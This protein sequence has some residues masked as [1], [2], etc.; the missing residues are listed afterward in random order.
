VAGRIQGA[1]KRGSCTGPVFSVY[2]RSS[3][4]AGGRAETG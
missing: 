3:F 4:P 2:H 1:V